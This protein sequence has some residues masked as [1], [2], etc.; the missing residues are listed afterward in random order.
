[1]YAMCGLPL[2]GETSEQTYIKPQDPI[3]IRPGSTV[4]NPCRVSSDMTIAI[5]ESL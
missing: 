5:L 3:G 4:P 1:M 2:V